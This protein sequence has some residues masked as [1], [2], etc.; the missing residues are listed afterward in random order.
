VLSFYRPL[1]FLFVGS[2]V[3][4]LQLALSVHYILPHRPHILDLGELG[5]L[6]SER[7]KE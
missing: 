1:S 4:P 3:P 5:I 2:L 6:V 7:K